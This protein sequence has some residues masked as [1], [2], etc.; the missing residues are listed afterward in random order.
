MQRYSQ[1]T[2][3]HDCHVYLDPFTGRWVAWYTD[4][5]FRNT[6]ENL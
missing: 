2:P 6:F 1:F 3:L 5:N 4:F